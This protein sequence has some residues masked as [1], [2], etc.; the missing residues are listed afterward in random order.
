MFVVRS[1]ATACPVAHAVPVAERLPII[2]RDAR[3]PE[4]P[5]RAQFPYAAPAAFTVTGASNGDVAR[6]TSLVLGRSKGRVLRPRL[7][8]GARDCSRPRN[9]TTGDQ[10]RSQGFGNERCRSAHGCGTD[11]PRTC[12]WRACHCISSRSGLHRRRASPPSGSQQQ[13]AGENVCRCYT[14]GYTAPVGAPSVWF[15]VYLSWTRNA[16]NSARRVR[17]LPTVRHPESGSACEHQPP[18]KGARVAGVPQHGHPLGREYTCGNLLTKVLSNHLPPVVKRPCCGYL[19]HRLPSH[20]GRRT[21]AWRGTCDW[22]VSVKATVTCRTCGLSDTQATRFWRSLLA[23]A[24][25]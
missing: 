5:R 17:I 21:H 1:S 13:W 2:P 12:S 18:K 16:L 11:L 24:R 3:S 7:H 23:K 15:G 8:H 14:N 19:K 22:Q 25:R 10:H 9:G 6:L 20:Q 4:E